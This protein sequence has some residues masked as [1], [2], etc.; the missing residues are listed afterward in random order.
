V[1]FTFV[2]ITQHMYFVP[3][4]LFRFALSSVAPGR[5]ASRVW[6]AQLLFVKAF[7]FWKVSF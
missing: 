2:Y 4:Y 7:K 5:E 3:T 1:D 6:E